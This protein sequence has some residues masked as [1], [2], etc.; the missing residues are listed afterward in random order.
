M[1]QQ[2][3]TPTAAAPAGTAPGEEVIATYRSY[4]EAQRAVDLLSDEG[5]P[6]EEVKIVGHDVSMVEQVT[7]RLTTARAALAGAGS[8]A[9]IGLF[10]GLLVGLFTTGPTWLGLVLG[11]LLL[12]ALWGAALGFFAHWATRGQRDF[13]SRSA[14]VAAS[15]DVVAA[16]ANAARGRELVSR[17]R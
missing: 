16:A 15:Y 12:G 17:V 7:G 5:F 1:N 10:V 9:W 11:G 3:P 6:V 8:G 2:E 13:A 14:L 4:G